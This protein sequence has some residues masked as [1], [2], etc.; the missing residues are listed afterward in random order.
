MKKYGFRYLIDLIAVTLI[1]IIALSIRI[2]YQHNSIIDDPPLQGDE[3]KYFLVA[4]NLYKFHVYSPDRP[5][6]PNIPPQENLSTPAPP[7]YPL[8]LYPFM[9]SSTRLR[10]FLTRVTK[11]Q[12]ILGSLTAVIAY[13]LARIC[14]TTP[15]ALMP[16]LLTALNPHLI[17]CDQYLLSESLFTFTVALAIL[18]LIISWRKNTPFLSIVSGVCFGYT[19]LLRPISMLLCPFMAVVYF[20]NPS[21]WSLASKK[22]ISVHIICL[23][24]GYA[25]IYSPYLIFRNMKT[26]SISVAGDSLWP[27]IIM[28]S[29]INLKYWEKVHIERDPFARFDQ[30]KMINDKSFGLSVFKKRFQSDPM[31]FIKWYSGGKI[32]FMWHWDNMYNGDVY[33]YPMLKKGFNTVP[34][35]RAIHTVMHALHWPLYVLTLI[36]PLILLISRFRNRLNP[37]STTLLPYILIFT[38]FAALLTILLPL[39]RYAIPLRPFSYILATA[40]LVWIIPFIKNLIFSKTTI[41]NRGYF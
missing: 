28:G 6:A 34:S 40:S 4:Y 18:I 27:Y 20:F 31:N 39:P 12:A 5:P 10:E 11:A 30:E 25:L 26:D 19:V 37:K 13:I 33:Q 41:I 14:F 23:L 15:W 16:G 24:I 8:F 32:L 3:A 21:K 38:Y 7:G 9:A 29:D 2:S 22:I 35:L 36:S 1:F 17:A